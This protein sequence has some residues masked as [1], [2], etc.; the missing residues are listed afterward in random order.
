[1]KTRS[2]KL[3]NALHSSS[4]NLQKDSTSSQDAKWFLLLMCESK[5]MEPGLVYVQEA[6][7][8][9]DSCQDFAAIQAS[10]WEVVGDRGGLLWLRCR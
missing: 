7:M 6:I 8:D 5:L 2:R 10:L 1:M 9:G 3:R 4:R